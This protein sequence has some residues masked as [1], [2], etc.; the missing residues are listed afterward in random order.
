MDSNHVELEN[1]IANDLRAVF[2][3]LTAEASS[4]LKDLQ[5]QSALTSLTAFALD[6]L[7]IGFAVI[8]FSTKEWHWTILA[9]V[10]VGSRQRALSNLV[11]DASHGNL[12]RTR[13]VNDWF[14]NLF[15]AFPMFE[16]VSLYR[17]AHALHHRN[18]GSPTVDPDSRAHLRYG[19]N[20][21]NPPS[22]SPAQVF[23]KLL[24]NHNAWY[25]SAFGNL[26]TLNGYDLARMGMW[27]ATA[28]ALLWLLCGEKFAA[29]FCLLW[30][31]SRATSYHAVR[32]FAEFLDHTGLNP[33]S[34][35][36][37]TRNLPHFGLFSAVFHPHQ[38][39]YHLTHHLLPKVPH[40]KLRKAHSM[41][42]HL[43]SY[44]SSHH[45][46]GYFSGKHSATACWMR[47]CQ[48]FRP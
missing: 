30:F 15:A 19:Y 32:L 46:D 12:F 6:W 17:K 48:E 35:F 1:S 11:H 27:W 8:L 20:D 22:G 10:I 13:R 24:S 42:M 16:S 9:L 23:L 47:T 21:A 45:C 2:S 5:V 43:P 7:L 14:T 31:L 44:Q 29:S 36:G 38:D 40:H 34:I 39:T 18:L 25:D 33:G 4:T 28:F 3:S 26:F 41:L 37:F